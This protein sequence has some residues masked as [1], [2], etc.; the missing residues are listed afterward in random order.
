[1][2]K[3]RST[4]VP[5][6][7][8]TKII[9][10]GKSYDGHITN[11]SEDGVGCSITSVL[12][13]PED[14]IPIKIPE[15]QFD[16]PSGRKVDL[17]CEL[18]W[19]SGTAP[20][21]SRLTIGLRVLEPPPHYREFISTLCGEGQPPASGEPATSA[22]LTDGFACPPVGLSSPEAASIGDDVYRK[23]VESTGD[24]IY[25]LNTRYQ[26]LFINPEHLSRLGGKNED[27]LGRLYQEFHSAE[28]TADFTKKFDEVVAS[29][30]PL[31]CEL[32][33]GRDGKY[34]LRSLSP[35]KDQKGEVIAVAVVSRNITD[36]KL[37]E[38]LF[39]KAVRQLEK[40]AEERAAALLALNENLQREIGDHQQTE[41]ALKKTSD[42]WR[43]TFDSTKD[44][45]I[46][47]NGDLRI[48]KVNKAV[49]RHL[50]KTYAGI[51]GCM[52]FDLFTD[53]DLPREEHPL[54]RSRKSEKHE[55]SE[56]Y[57]KD[58][59]IWVLASADPIMD[60]DGVL[61]GAVL[62]I[63][64]ISEQKNLQLQL[65]QSQKMD[66]V[67]RLAGGVAHDFNNILSSILGYTELALLKLP[68][69]LP[70][71]EYLTAV[72][73]SGERAAALTQHLLAF[74]RKQVLK[75]RV[76][77]LNSVIENTAKMM[78]RVIRE[79]IRLE[80]HLDP[81]LQSV[82][83]D[84]LQLDQIFMNLIINARDAMPGGGTLILG[85]ANITLDHDF[86]VR[87]ENVRPG[88]YVMFSVSDTGTGMS[89]QV[90]GKIFEPF[91]TTKPVGK[92][93]GFGLSTVYGIVSQHNGYIYAYSEVGRGT[94]FK[95]YLPVA[96]EQAEG[97]APKEVMTMPRGTETVLVVDDDPS[98]R[99]LIR[100]ILEPLGYRLIFA[101]DGE[102]ALRLAQEAGGPV[103]LLLT[104]VVM[105]NMNGK[106]LADAFHQSY[107]R[108]KVIFMT[109]Y[110][111]EAVYQ[112]GD[113]RPQDVLI[114]KPL[115]PAKLAGI[116]RKVLD[117]GKEP[118]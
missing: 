103:D 50:G 100:D 90:L 12:K 92:G 27:Y 79:D 17:R 93:T 72:K 37:A 86:V 8:D 15:L 99:R 2:G 118:G 49:S 31:N 34:F 14:F 10:A 28:E 46:M 84:P 59:N 54:E 42:E 20:D 106:Q 19:F 117:L 6:S 116:L 94:T 36:R 18:A 9:L 113:L 83:A 114:Q 61:A 44:M 78:V 77:N 22:H 107:P 60:G 45:I 111:D 47:L 38:N 1:M 97:P 24:A 11:V 98:I 68:D 74:S 52:F 64:D 70:V 5:V 112:Q 48:I 4:R 109:G 62:T 41:L 82:S 39:L 76:V 58:S 43:I 88:P 73:E 101:S 25:I 23:F 26:Y 87:H 21:D 96:D 95:V 3:R 89:K 55:E 71:R 115:S 35:V 40:Q 65:L 56:V 102:E 33:S 75:M 105:P 63:R 85:T 91:F 67:G 32:K 80:L 53:M 66:S 7:L 51:I 81:R 57:L 29:G 69:N 104:D 108:A 13:A 16:L 110:T 30:I